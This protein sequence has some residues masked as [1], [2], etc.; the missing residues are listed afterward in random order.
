M[1]RI[2]LLATALFAAC[3]TP[4]PEEAP[5][6][7][8]TEAHDAGTEAAT[9]PTTPDGVDFGNDLTGT[10]TS[11][12]HVVM[13]VTGK[14]VQPAG[15]VIE[16]SGHHHIIID[17]EP[18]AEGEVV[19]ADDKHIHFGAGQTETDVELTPG[20]HTLTL[21][22]ANGAHQSY[23]AD[24]SKTITVTVGEGGTDGGEESAH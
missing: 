5:E 10:L 17:G 3:S 4:A 16:G 23:G 18:I 11:P 19:P 6:P 12:V 9:E 20:E 7:A 1:T 2:A 21:Q 13:T 15:E 8:A 14:T 22:F 24:W